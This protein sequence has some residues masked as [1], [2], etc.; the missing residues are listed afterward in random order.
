M[1]RKILTAVFAVVIYISAAAQLNFDYFLQQQQLANQRAYNMGS[2]MGLLM[3]GQSSL[4][5]GDY[6]EAFEAFEEAADV[7]E[8]PAAFEYVGICYELGIGCERNLE[9]ADQYY[10]DGANLYKNANCKQQIR[11]I[12]KDGHYPASFRSTFLRNFKNSYAAIYGGGS[13][14]NYN[15]GNSNSSGGGS[16]YSSCRTCGG[17]GVCTSCGG[18]G[19]E[20]RDT[21]YYT[22]SGN[23]SWIDCPSCRGNK[24]CFNCHGTGKY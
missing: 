22:G 16:A 6:K 12:N 4:A 13:Y 15:E 3:K 2:A 7:Y 8:Y 14:G 20:W 9:W 21:G 11:R 10:E 24:K 1:I 18:K 23:K 17:S 19:G 5:N